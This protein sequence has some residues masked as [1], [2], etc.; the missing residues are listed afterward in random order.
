MSDK[1]L[2]QL[3]YPLLLNAM[4]GMVVTLIDTM[5]ISAYSEDAVAAV[6]IANQILLVAFD[7][8]A[9]FAFGAVVMVSKCLGS[10]D[11][12][13]AMRMAQAAILGN[14]VV[15]LLLGVS[16]LLFSDV[17][18]ALINCPAEI[19]GDA[20][21]YLRVGGFTILFNGVMMAATAILRG[22]GETRTILV[23]G[24]AAYT[25]YLVS[26]YLLIFGLGP[27]PELG[28]FG[29][30]LATLLVRVFAVGV[31]GLVLIRRLW[32]S[33]T[34]DTGF[35]SNLQDEM[36]ESQSDR[37]SVTSSSKFRDKLNTVFLSM[38]IRSY[39]KT[40]SDITSR[41]AAAKPKSCTSIGRFRALFHLSWPSAVDNLAYGFYQMILVSF[42]AQY[43]VAMLLSRTFTLSLSAVLTV[44]LM[45]ISQANEVMVGYRHGANRERELNGCL[46]RSTITST[47]LTTSIAVAI[48][49]FS[50]PLIGLFTEDL[51]IH[52][53]A[54]RLLWITVFVQ[55]FSCVNTI[56]FHS[57]KAVGDAFVPVAGTQVMMWGLSV[58]L[59]YL[60]AVH[61]H[62]GVIG[63]W[64]VLLMEEALKSLF[65]LIRWHFKTMRVAEFRSS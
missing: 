1:T 55:P 47:L 16:I 57:L 48:Y 56:L 17:F 12:T 9:V 50:Q 32:R 53:V 59:A 34:E 43:N 2:F 49:W 38:R 14:A 64:Y 28:V 24:T 41:Q 29:S 15:S 51:Q 8:S 36:I 4:I 31:L 23:L 26:E 11:F 52:K 63:L 45:S 6:S 22:Y 65:L 37:V 7:L 33:D 21:V 13:E 35:E 27:I 40:N 25:L 20:T 18:V 5:I 54:R 61:L 30:A 3:S 19:V 58:P 60:L 44:V 39:W 42:I 10:R 46:V 62:L